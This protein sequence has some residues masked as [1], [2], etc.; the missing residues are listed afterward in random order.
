MA[1]GRGEMFRNAL[2][3]SLVFVVFLVTY[4][5]LLLP[6]HPVVDLGQVHTG[7]VIDADLVSSVDFRRSLL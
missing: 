6:D 3:G 4:F 7:Q 2:T 1:T 5:F